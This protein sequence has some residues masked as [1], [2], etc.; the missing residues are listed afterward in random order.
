MSLNPDTPSPKPQ[1]KK[2]TS[3]SP[4]L[5]QL[6]RAR[7]KTDPP[8]TAR[9]GGKGKREEEENR[10]EQRGRP[11]KREERRQKAKKEGQRIIRR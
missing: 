6:G 10:R 11:K 7:T 5:P 3:S 1:R 4:R 9:R 8:T 2:V